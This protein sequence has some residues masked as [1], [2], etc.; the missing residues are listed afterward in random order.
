MGVLF[1]FEAVYR[2]EELVMELHEKIDL[3]ASNTDLASFI[4]DLRVDLVSNAGDWENS[5]L[6]R[7]LEAMS[8]WV[9]SMENVY[10]NT[11]KVFPEQPSWK[12]IADI[13]YA[14]KIYE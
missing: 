12:M 4:E 9:N 13:L 7:L 2:L 14:A 6:E 8:V 5:N 11:G 10:R 3:I 1:A